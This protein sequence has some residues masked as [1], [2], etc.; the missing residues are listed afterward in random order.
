MAGRKDIISQQLATMENKRTNMKGADPT[1]RAK[2]AV[3]R[4]NSVDTRKIFTADSALL[5]D[6][7]L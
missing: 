7:E 3:K 2:D 6:E 1:D 5:K 4:N